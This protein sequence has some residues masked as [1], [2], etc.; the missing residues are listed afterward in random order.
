MVAATADIFGYV[1]GRMFGKNH[2]FP[3]ISPNKTSEGLI[4]GIVMGILVGLV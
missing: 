3:N 4:I 2:P 1:G